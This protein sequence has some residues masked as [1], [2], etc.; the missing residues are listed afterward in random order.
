MMADV[1]KVAVTTPIRAVS[2]GL[3]KTMSGIKVL[4]YQKRTFHALKIGA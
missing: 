2:A 4:I 3:P 1:L